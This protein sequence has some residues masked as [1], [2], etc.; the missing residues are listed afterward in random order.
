VPKAP[1]IPAALTRGPFDLDEARRHGLTKDHLLGASWQRLGGGFYALRA[2]AHD[3][4]V[5]LAATR[6]RLPAKAVFSG[7]TAGWLHGLDLAPCDPVEATLPL[8]SHT[9]RLTGITVRRSDFDPSDTVMRRGHPTT[10]VVRTL[11]DLGRHRPLVEAVAALDMALHQRLL[12]SDDL[13]SWACAHPSYPGI[14]RLRR[15]IELADPATESVMETKLRLLL[16]M[17]RLPRPQAQVSL[18]DKAGNFLGRSDFYYPLHRLAL[19][20]D[21]A[22]HRESLTEDNR[23]QNRLVDA[24]YRL[25]RFTAADVL[26]SPESVVAL[27]RRALS[28]H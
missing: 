20:Y 4:N 14:R 28:A 17:A 5:V 23:R 3:P 18:Y 13:R 19:E 16:V 6:R 2:I 12:E 11:A 22:H 24:G 15:T 25:L 9:S 21:G 1:L 8:G 26:S 27:V 7:R 10:S